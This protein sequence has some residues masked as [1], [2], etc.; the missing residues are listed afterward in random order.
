MASGN[1]RKELKKLHDQAVLPG[2][3]DSLIHEIVAEKNDRG[4][5]LITGI[6]VEEALRRA[7]LSRFVPSDATD[8]FS[9]Q[10]ALSTFYNLTAIG[11][12]MGLFDKQIRSDLDRIREIRNAF[13]HCRFPTTFET[14]AIADACAGFEVDSV[15]Y[16]QITSSMNPAKRKYVLASLRV[17]DVL[18]EL[19]RMPRH[20]GSKPITYVDVAEAKRRRRADKMQPHN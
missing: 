1:W 20:Q 14:T 7:V 2:V 16:K 12:G 8:L 13:A 17:I 18:N 11:Y 9:R 6:L 15:N 3:G 5:A 10:S 4:A 19:R